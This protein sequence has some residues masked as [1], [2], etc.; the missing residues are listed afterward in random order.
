M[1]LFP[2]LPSPNYDNCAHVCTHE[3]NAGRFA[4]ERERALAFLEVGGIAIFVH[5]RPLPR[6]HRTREYA[7]GRARRFRGHGHRLSG[8][9]VH[10]IDQERGW[11]RLWPRG[12]L[13]ADGRRQERPCRERLLWRRRLRRGSVERPVTV[14]FGYVYRLLDQRLR[15]VILVHLVPSA[16][17]RLVPASN[18]QRFRFFFAFPRPFTAEYAIES[19]EINRFPALP[20]VG[21]GDCFYFI[22]LIILKKNVIGYR[23]VNSFD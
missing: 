21:L 13:I 14:R 22:R 2:S 8:G 3:L 6:G 23:F 5:G 7:H 20:S 16:S 19:N 12:R 15:P 11:P 4:I 1:S 17:D 18:P 9:R 10:R